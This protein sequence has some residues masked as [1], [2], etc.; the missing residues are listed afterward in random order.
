MPSHTVSLIITE[1]SDQLSHQRLDQLV[2]LS[3]PRLPAFRGRL[4]GGPLGVG[5]PLWAEIVDSLDTLVAAARK[6][7]RGQGVRSSQ[8]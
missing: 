3:L 4:V 7:P 8:R 6:S 1:P 2:G 5:R